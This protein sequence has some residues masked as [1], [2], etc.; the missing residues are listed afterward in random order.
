SMQ[1]RGVCGEAAGR[2]TARGRD[3]AQSKLHV[4]SRELSG[5]DGS[6]GTEPEA[7]PA[8]W[9]EQSGGRRLDRIGQA[10]LWDSWNAPTGAGRP[11][12]VAR[13]F[14]AGELECGIFFTNGLDRPAGVCGA[15]GKGE[16][17]NR[18]VR[19]TLHILRASG[20]L[21]T[22]T[23]RLTIGYSKRLARL[24]RA[25][26]LILFAGIIMQGNRGMGMFA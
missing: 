7:Q 25:V 12:G 14:P 9:T 21:V 1:H 5:I 24:N 6:A 23:A 17:Q 8:A 2:R 10:G 20:N 18:G 26:I 3:C 15:V 22:Y 16:K 19:V 11:R 4:R 13:L